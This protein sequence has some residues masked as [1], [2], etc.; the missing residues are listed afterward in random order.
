[1][2]MFIV[3]VIQNP[4]GLLYK[5]QTQSL[6]K[7]LLEHNDPNGSHSYTRNKGPWILVHQEVCSTRSEAMK[8]ERYFK[9]GAGRDYLNKLL[10]EP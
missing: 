7:R 3:Y 2:I 6:K 8:R 9:T 5:G 4:S 1:M 10:K